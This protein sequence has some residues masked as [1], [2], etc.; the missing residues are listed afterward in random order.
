MTVTQNSKKDVKLIHLIVSVLECFRLINFSSR[1]SQVESLR[2]K[3]KFL[4]KSL[5]FCFNFAG[6]CSFKVKKNVLTI[7]NFVV[8][9]NILN[10]PIYFACIKIASKLI[11]LSKG[12]K[13]VLPPRSSK[14]LVLMLKSNKATNV[15][16]ICLCTYIQLWKRK[17]NPRG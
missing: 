3:M 8:L 17:E 1:F 13:F 6:I 10:I 14:L 12:M 9:I 15:I 4:Y 16:M 2:R 11:N 5:I 7:S